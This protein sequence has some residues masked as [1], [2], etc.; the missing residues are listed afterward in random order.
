MRSPVDWTSCSTCDREDIEDLRLCVQWILFAKRP[1]RPEEYF[2]AIRK[3]SSPETDKCWLSGDISPEDMKLFVQNASKGLAQLTETRSNLETSTVQFIHES[4]R[5]FFLVNR[6]YLRLWPSLHHHFVPSSH[7]VL[8]NRCMAEITA[9][10]T[11]NTILD[12]IQSTMQLPHIETRLP[13]GIDDLTYLYS[14]GLLPTMGLQEPRLS[15][16][17][18]PKDCPF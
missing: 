10:A 9:E 13:D 14:S 15:V 3:A 1:L 6:G 4:V 16:E 5:D 18:C 11:R 17:N 2:F 7:E 12:V 8:L